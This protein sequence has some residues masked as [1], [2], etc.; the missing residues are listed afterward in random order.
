[1]HDMIMKFVKESGEVLYIGDAYEWRLQKTGAEGF[2]EF[3]GDLSVT[4]D[5]SRDGGVTDNIRIADVTRTLK[6][7]NVNCRNNKANREAIQKFFTYKAKYKI[8]ITF[9]GVTRWIEGVLYR[10][11]MNEPTNEDYL[12]KITASFHFDNPYFLSV[13]NFGK[14]I[15]E[16]TPYFAF[17]WISQVGVGTASGIFNY[18]RSVILKNDGDNIAYPRI[19]IRF[20]DA[21][22]NPVVSINNGYIRFIGT[23][24]T[25]DSI[26]IDY[27]VN[28]PKITNNG[29]NI[30]GICDR[31][32]KFDDMYIMIGENT[33]SFDADN[34]SDEMSVSVYYN[35]LYMVI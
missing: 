35:R 6:I 13:D 21:V 20:R 7:C 4:Q 33:I 30:M 1:M 10:M 29:V 8:Y 15:A 34:G 11:A 24:N 17:P 16:L 3:T 32:S 9:E 22:V 12:L 31:A 23:F 2:S 19:D 26:N 18:T 28:P 14:D 27:T 25:S 5:Y